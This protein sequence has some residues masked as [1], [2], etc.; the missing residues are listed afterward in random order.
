MSTSL[1]K[2]HISHSITLTNHTKNSD[3]KGFLRN[4]Q[5]IPGMWLRKVP[6]VLRS[7]QAYLGRSLQPSARLNL[8]VRPSHRSCDSS[9]FANQSGAAKASESTALN[10][11]AWPGM[12]PKYYGVHSLRKNTEV[13]MCEYIYTYDIYIYIC[14]SLCVCVRLSCIYVHHVV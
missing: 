8:E 5:G 12:Q 11:C 13:C 9:A 10:T 14:V 2:L 7:W 6:G 4:G 3:C 1:L